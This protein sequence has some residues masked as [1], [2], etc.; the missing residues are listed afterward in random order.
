MVQIVATSNNQTLGRGKKRYPRGVTLLEILVAVGVMAF[1]ISAIMQIFPVG[2]ADST[3]ASY[4]AIA[5][6]LAGQKMEEIRGMYLFGG[7]PDVDIKSSASATNSYKDTYKFFGHRTHPATAVNSAF[8]ETTMLGNGN[9][10]A[11]VAFDS[12]ATAMIRPLWPSIAGMAPV[13]R[14][15]ISTASISCPW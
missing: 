5:Y 10:T 9:D 15:V 8:T 4:L 3:R 12:W 2:F 11:F 6:E 1:A 13:W 7:D 14:R